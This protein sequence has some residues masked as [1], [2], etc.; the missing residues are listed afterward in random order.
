MVP[1][2]RDTAVGGQQ[3]VSM[4]GPIWETKLRGPSVVVYQRPGW[5]HMGDLTLWATRSGISEGGSYWEVRLCGS[6][7]SIRR[8][9]GSLKVN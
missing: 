2:G 1:G 4:G 3:L 5:S 7:L 6:Q 8:Y 9:L